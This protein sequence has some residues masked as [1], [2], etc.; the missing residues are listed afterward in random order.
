MID[1]LDSEQNKNNFDGQSSKTAAIKE[2]AA[3]SESYQVLNAELEDLKSKLRTV[4]TGLDYKVNSL[5]ET[6]TISGNKK[7]LKKLF[8]W[9]KLMIKV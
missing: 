3:Y 8:Q 7:K 5:T 1:S 6:M 4:N 2:L 9:Q